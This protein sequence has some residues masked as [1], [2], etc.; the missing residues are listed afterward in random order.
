MKMAE[1]ATQTRWQRISAEIEALWTWS[2]QN[3]AGMR[4]HD[5]ALVGKSWRP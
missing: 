5:L 3:N 4:R 1:I 2:R